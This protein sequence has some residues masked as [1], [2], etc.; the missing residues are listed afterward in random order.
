MKQDLNFTCVIFSGSTC[1][2]LTACAHTIKEGTQQ[3]L[4]HLGKEVM[5]HL[6]L[7]EGK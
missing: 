2:L 3:S 6:S 1:P 4:T 5:N 7:Q